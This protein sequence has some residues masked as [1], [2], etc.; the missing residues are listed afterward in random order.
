MK[1]LRKS[2]LLLIAFAL[3]TTNASAQGA[4]RKPPKEIEDVLNAP[5]LPTTSVSPAHDKI[6]LAQ[7]LRY[8]PISELAQPMLRLAGSRINPNTNGQ[9]RQN[10]FVALT[11][12]NIDDGRETSIALPA[13]AQVISPNWSADGKYI[14]FGNQT[15]N[16][17]ELWILDT[18]SA[19][20]KQLKNIRVNTAFG[21]FDWMPD[22][23]S[24]LVNLVP[25]KRAAVLSA[26]SVP[27]E[28]SVQETAGKTGLVQTFQD[29]LKNPSDE[30]LF[31]YYA[32]S[33][34]AVVSLDGKTKEIGQPAI[35]ETA[36]ASPDG[37]HVLT[38]R[39]E[40]P[41]SYLYPAPR[42][43]KTIEVWDLDGKPLYKLASLPLADNLPAQGVPVG[44]RSY[45]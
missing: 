10:Y 3:L 40:R 44:A 11:L 9:H 20:A 41:F 29:L 31:E 4:Y 39:I 13:G 34:L 7:P 2:F 27:S 5:A 21:K 32:T 24:L 42:F 25:A 22:Q 18:A 38:A 16:G 28:P 37:R 17:I 23:K 26:S 12:K 45:G 30:R 8:P 19:Q 36:E 1:N 33:Q 43:P 15:A 35:F 6:L 14:A